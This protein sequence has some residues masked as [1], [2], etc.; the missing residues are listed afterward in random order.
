MHSPTNGGKVNTKYGH[1]NTIDNNEDLKIGNTMT[2]EDYLQKWG[3][4]AA[5]DIDTPISD[6][7][8][9]VYPGVVVWAYKSSVNG[10]T[11]I[12]I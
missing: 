1:Q 8:Y 4:H 6:D 2:K 3:V 10:G 12:V 7:I 11:K 9:A 5:V